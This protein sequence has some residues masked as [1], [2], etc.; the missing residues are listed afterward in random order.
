[1]RKR[2]NL[3]DAPIVIDPGKSLVLEA[4]D[5]NQAISG[6]EIEWHEIGADKTVRAVGWATAVAGGATAESFIELWNAAAS[7][8]VLKVTAITVYDGIYPIKVKHHTAQQGSG[9]TVG[10]KGNKLFG[11]VAPSAALYGDSAASVSGTQ[12]F[13]LNKGAGE[14]GGSG[15]E[16]SSL[17]ETGQTNSY[18]TGDDGD[19]ELGVKKN[20]TVLSTGQYSGTSNIVINAKTHALSNNCVQDNRT[21]LMWARYVP[22]ADI[23]PAA[24]GKL[25]W[26]Q[27]ALAAESC[28]FTAVDKKITAAAG[29]PFN[30]GALCVGRKITITGTANNN[31]VV[32][33]VAI[34]TSVITVSEVLTNE[35]PVNTTFATLDDLI[36]DALAQ[37]NANSLG[38]YNDWRIPN[39]F[40]L[41]S[42]INLGD[43][44][45]AIDTAVFPSTPA[46]YH[47]TASTR[48]CDTA[49][50]FHVSFHH[51]HVYSTP[52]QSSKYYVRFVRG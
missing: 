43:C 51:G 44:N 48:P 5:S 9:G 30:I 3:N 11:G 4:K 23:G 28:T 7:G 21:G 42:I 12:V 10:I 36:W 24:G 49:Y 35:G 13:E 33:V 22:T 41:P 16:L 25:F 20:Y 17:L 1:M 31:G 38:G 52:M 19:L 14:A 26:E 40:E 18:A 39:Y 37:A 29:A 8:K 45:P 46:A 6:V 34:T 32:T 15:P 47:W 27:W 2:F 50:A